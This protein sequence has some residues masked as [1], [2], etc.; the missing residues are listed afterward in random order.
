MPAHARRS[1]WLKLTI[2]N[3]LARAAPLSELRRKVSR[4]QSSIKRLER[5]F[6]M[7][8][9]RRFRAPKAGIID[10]QALPS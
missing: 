8:L 7:L 3:R 9:P 6:R 2:R 1:C 10:F 4:S 5:V